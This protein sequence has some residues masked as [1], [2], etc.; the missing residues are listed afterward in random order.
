MMYKVL[1]VCDCIVCYCNEKEYFLSNLKLQKLL[2]FVQAYFLLT[3][4]EPCFAE[5]LEAWEFGPVVPE[6]YREYK[7]Y[8]GGNI[9]ALYCGRDAES[10]N[11]EDRKVIESVVDH[12]ADY[13]ATDLK[14]LT[15]R[16]KPWL[17]AYV[18]DKQKEITLNS[19]RAYFA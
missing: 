11:K 16:Q 13:S 6:A 8:G 2:Y 17:D 4:G 18:P 1:P 9:P 7:R 3:K 5:K 12:F 10:I 19:I 15:Q 14:E